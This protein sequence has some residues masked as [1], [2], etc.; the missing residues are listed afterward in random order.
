MNCFLWLKGY[1]EVGQVKIWQNNDVQIIILHAFNCE[2]LCVCVF[3]LLCLHVC[4]HCKCISRWKQCWWEAGFA[5]LVSSFSVT[6]SSHCCVYRSREAQR[7]QR[8]HCL[9]LRLK[10][11]QI[12]TITFHIQSDVQ[13]EL[14]KYNLVM[15][16]YKCQ[17]V[18]IWRNT[19]IHSWI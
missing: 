14:T 12:T 2:Y 9:P 15:L 6:L 11:T 19:S 8:C 3:L 10:H 17:I 1:W 4:S 16:K 7:Q 13:Q 18:D 5:R